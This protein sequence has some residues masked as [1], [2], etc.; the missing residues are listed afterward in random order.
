MTRSRDG[1]ATTNG[2][3]ASND[4]VNASDLRAM[5]LNGGVRPSSPAKRAASELDHN[6]LDQS[7][8]EKSPSKLSGTPLASPLP[9]RTRKESV[10]AAEDDEN[11]VISSPSVDDQLK[12][13]LPLIQHHEMLEGGKAYLVPLSWINRLRSRTT[14]GRQSHEFADESRQGDVGGIDTRE[15]VPSS[16][17]SD[18]RNLQ[19]G[20]GNPVVP[21]KPGLQPGEDY[22]FLP[23]RAWDLV[24]EWYGLAEGAPILTRFV[25]DTSSGDGVPNYQ[26]ELYP[27]IVTIQKV[28]QIRERGLETIGN[29]NKQAA[30]LFVSRAEKYQDFLKRAKIAAGIDM[31]IKVKVWKILEPEPN[32]MPTP[33]PSRGSSP[34]PQAAPVANTLQLV[35]GSEVLSAMPIGTQR[36]ELEFKDET[37]NEK[38]NGSLPIAS[39][40]FN[41]VQTVVLEELPRTSSHEKHRLAKSNDIQS[42]KSIITSPDS[43]AQES[44]KAATATKS[45]Q[46][47]A[48]QT[49]PQTR[50]R[51]NK[52]TRSQGTV[53]LSNLGNTCY[54]NSALQCLRS[55]EELTEYFLQQAHKSEINTDNPLGNSGAVAN[56]YA[57]LVHTLY[58]TENGFAPRNFKSVISR[59]YPTFS[60]YGQ[61]DSQEFVSTLLDGV[62][63]DV[64]RIHKKPYIENPESDDK[65]VNNPEAI[66]MLGAKFQGNFRKRNDSVV[67]DLFNGWY[68]NTLVCPVCNKVSITFD[69]FSQVTLQLPVDNTF[70]HQITF[71]PL[72]ETPRI[73]NVDIDKNASIRSLKE[74]C[75]QRVP[76]VKVEN[77]VIAEEYQ[78]KFYK[79]FEDAMILSEE[80]ISNNDI[81]T[82]HEL[83]EPPTNWPPLDKK[84]SRTRTLLTS[85]FGGMA[86]SNAVPSMSSSYADRMAIPVTQR[87][88][89]GVKTSFTNHPFFVLITREEA[90]DSDLVFRKIL[91]KV[92]TMTTRDL[93]NESDFSITPPDTVTSVNG[94]DG[95]KSDEQKVEMGSADGEDGFVDI[96]LAREKGKPN[97]GI[98]NTPK[99]RSKILDQSYFID[100]ELRNM[101]ELGI[102]T[103]SEIMP[104]GYSAINDSTKL[105]KLGDRM[106]RQS[107]RR[108]SVDS[109]ARSTSAR[110]DR[111]DTRVSESVSDSE[112]DLTK[113]AH[114][115]SG[116]VS[117]SQPQSE[118]EDLAMNEDGLL[119]TPRKS[120]TQRLRHGVKGWAKNMGR[121]KSRSEDYVLKLG[122]MLI[123][124][125]N[126]DGFDQMFGG[127]SPDDFKGQQTDLKI[128]IVPDPE[129][130]KKRERRSA[131]KKSGVTLDECFD[132][133]SKS[134]VLS[135][136]NSWYC[137]RCKELRRATK[138]LELW[139]VPDILVIHLKRFGS[140]GRIGRDKVD[141]DVNFPTD[142]LDLNSRVGTANGRD[143]TYDLFAVDNHMGGLGGGHY[144]AHAKNFIDEQW[145]EYNDSF[146]SRA[147]A[148]SAVNRS[149]YLLFYRRRSDKPLGSPRLQELVT[150]ANK[151]FS[152]SSSPSDDNDNASTDEASD[153]M[154]AARFTLNSGPTSGMRGG[155]SGFAY[156]H[157]DEGYVDSDPDA[158]LPGIEDRPQNPSALYSQSGW[159]F[160]SIGGAAAPSNSINGGNDSDGLRDDD[161]A[162][163][164]VGHGS[165]LGERMRDFED[166]DYGGGGQMAAMPPSEFDDGDVE[167][168][169]MV[170]G[171]VDDR[172]RDEEVAEVMLTDDDDERMGG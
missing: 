109:R 83:D 144:T 118:D 64:N 155:S 124:D 35:V 50:G 29:A 161:A 42:T 101:F 106:P 115:V 38:Y 24:N 95:K 69:P 74:Y 56:V 59:I 13:I 170:G 72:R 149:A 66:R 87:L 57:G 146:V 110:N 145:Y 143:L 73:I 71:F 157:P 19:D 86:E 90:K 18:L 117:P 148:K 65:T 165:E 104:T 113:S 77:L 138:T 52:R 51:S 45:I 150:K 32:A 82:I 75:A 135:E 126:Q 137:G 76:G 3:D 37:A 172:S 70:Q 96:S 55:V 62:H 21:I 30:R 53:G 44:P 27:P 79:Y 102:F 142:G 127:D 123:L 158:P 78:G 85:A 8:F 33:E 31:G 105:T 166:E 99:R 164:Q 20:F 122:E 4:S 1:S 12:T 108:L 81:L 139:A 120:T 40:G 36:E 22:E 5:T 171:D 125:W 163:D 160:K 133:S 54:M 10:E 154:P 34:V 93:C 58:N 46:M 129:L 41:Q 156:Q 111:W 141:I 107:H 162:S 121:S 2:S 89:K 6:D 132:E 16:A 48:Q 9:S 61:Q 153:T 112:D 26:Y 88:I 151:P 168:V 43:I 25:R 84:K 100:A 119:S 28:E 94:D 11:G 7:K 136:D 103:S 14:E 17:S 80:T 15:L 67:V 169:R 147:S 159:S 91:Q 60:G 98:A 23:Q 152:R 131:R 39:I 68:K 130:E 49:T 63:E 116:L 167:H 92:D 97:A 114:S 128:P 140:G 134:E 47:S